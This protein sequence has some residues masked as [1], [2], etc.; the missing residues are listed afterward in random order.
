MHNLQENEV[1]MH[2]CI[3]TLPGVTYPRDTIG[4]ESLHSVF[5]FFCFPA[6]PI[7]ELGMKLVIVEYSLHCFS[8]D[9]SFSLWAFQNLVMFELSFTFIAMQVI[10]LNQ[11]FLFLIQPI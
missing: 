9:M 2:T 7:H 5:V 6:A 11:N 8:L 4:R 10:K 3:L 1:E